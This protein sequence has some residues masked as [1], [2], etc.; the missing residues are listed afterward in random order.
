MLVGA[1]GEIV[2]TAPTDAADP[3]D[4]GPGRVD[5]TVFTQDDNGLPAPGVRV[6]FVAR[7]GQLIADV[8]ADPE[9]KASAIVGPEG[10]TVYVVRLPRDITGIVGA[11]PGDQLMFGSRGRTGSTRGTMTVQLPPPGSGET[12]VVETGCGTASGPSTSSSLTLVI[13]SRCQG[14]TFPLL[15]TAQSGNSVSGALYIPEV[16]FVSNGTVTIPGWPQTTSGIFT[17]TGVPTGVANLDIGAKLRTADSVLYTGLP[18]RIPVN[19]SMATMYRGLP[20]AGTT[21][22]ISAKMFRADAVTQ[23]FT[24][25]VPL[26]TAYTASTAGIA[27]FLTE[28]FHDFS[29]RTLTWTQDGGGAIDATVIDGRWY[30]YQ[31]SSNY[32]YRLIMPPSET[33]SFRFPPLPAALDDFTLLPSEQGNFAIHHL[34]FNPGVTYDHVR[35]RLDLAIRDDGDHDAFVHPNI[36]TVHHVE[37]ETNALPPPG[38]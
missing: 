24:Q 16:T 15:A 14:P 35:A 34:R 30:R 27:P 5:V 8:T 28:A 4:A 38:P 6:V 12:F 25:R 10:A 11:V 19:E 26:T 32:N 7:D 13:D 2:P 3:V 33:A 37:I 20:Q 31:N 23:Q 17:L 36:T 22:E 1:C 18:V 9:G 29:T 21:L